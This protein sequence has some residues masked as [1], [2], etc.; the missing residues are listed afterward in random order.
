MN[1]CF[2]SHAGGIPLGADPKIDQNSY[3]ADRIGQACMF[4][5]EGSIGQSLEQVGLVRFHSGVGGTGQNSFKRGQDWSRV[6]A[7]AGG[8][9]QTFCRSG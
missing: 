9:S 5:G 6:S 4:V 7:G 8:F 3:G 1:G 2:Y